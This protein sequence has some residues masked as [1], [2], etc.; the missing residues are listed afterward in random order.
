MLHVINK[1]DPN[2]ELNSRSKIHFYF[3]FF[4]IGVLRNVSQCNVIQQIEHHG[5]IHTWAWYKTN[6]IFGIPNQE[7]RLLIHK[8]LLVQSPFL[9]VETYGEFFNKIFWIWTSCNKLVINLMW[10]ITQFVLFRIEIIIKKK[11]ILPGDMIPL[12]RFSVTKINPSKYSYFTNK[13][14]RRANFCFHN[15]CSFHLCLLCL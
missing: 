15:L 6:A 8:W 3:D 2:N 14:L 1:N 13:L 4:P 12:I 5:I 9:D 7:H 10:I 11:L